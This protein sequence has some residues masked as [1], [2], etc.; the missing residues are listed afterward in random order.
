MAIRTYKGTRNSVHFITPVDD[1]GYLEAKQEIPLP[2]E[3]ER[4]RPATGILIGACISLLFWL[5]AMV[6]FIWMS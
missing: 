1:H 3:D 5:I 6:I 4:L 2:I